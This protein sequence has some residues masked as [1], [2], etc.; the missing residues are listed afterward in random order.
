MATRR[1]RLPPYNTRRA[2]LRTLLLVALILLALTALLEV[3]GRKGCVASGRRTH[4][5]LLGED[6]SDMFEGR[7]VPCADCGTTSTIH[8]ADCLIVLVW[9]L[10]GSIEQATGTEPPPERPAVAAVAGMDVLHEWI[11]KHGA[12]D[13]SVAATLLGLLVDH[14]MTIKSGGGIKR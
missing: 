3:T 14:Q 13:D 5:L 4:W 2:P 6:G 9:N 12:V 10:V 7:N 1:Q 11:N 8:R